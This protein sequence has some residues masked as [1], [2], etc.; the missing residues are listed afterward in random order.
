[1]SA[2]TAAKRKIDRGTAAH[3]TS[4]ANWA[5]H[6][7]DLWRCELATRILPRFALHL[8][9]PLTTFVRSGFFVGVTLVVACEKDATSAP[10]K[11]I[12]SA[13]RLLYE[14]SVSS[15]TRNVFQLSLV[16]LDGSAPVT[17][18]ANALA[19]PNASWSHDG[20]RIAFV[21][22][23][24]SIDTVNYIR[25]VNADG[26]GA[27]NLLKPFHSAALS[28]PSWSADGSEIAFIACDQSPC[29]S[30][31]IW[32][33]KTDGTSLHAFPNTTQLSPFVSGSPLWSPDGTK[34][35]YPYLDEPNQESYGEKVVD[36]TTGTTPIVVVSR[37]GFDAGG[38]SLSSYAWAPTSDHLAFAA[39]QFA[40]GGPGPSAVAT[41]LI[42][43]SDGSN[44]LGTA[45][46]NV[47][48]STEIMLAWSPSGTALLLTTF[49]NLPPYNEAT[50]SGSVFTLA[51]DGTNETTLA[52]YRGFFENPAW[53]PDGRYVSFTI[54][55]VRGETPGT[56]LY[57][58]PTTGGNAFAVTSTDGIVYAA[59][60]QP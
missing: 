23:S 7:F 54:S 52:S 31:V 18:V 56:N 29:D 15:G 48:Q 20:S 30:L 1:M 59:S 41:A 55:G 38:I 6:S 47:P 57:A 11:A 60:W 10:T 36:T 34:I 45:I 19:P 5:P 49:N 21:Y 4:I 27:V 16:N 32:I 50:L 3:H 26:S 44:T 25:V 37:R 8:M 51:P 14:T 17:L 40:Q 43:P 24:V 39:T 13:Y 9:R 35:A 22:D 28:P 46:P 58:M 53:S 33:A 42:V 12:P 2:I